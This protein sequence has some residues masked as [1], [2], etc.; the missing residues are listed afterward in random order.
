MCI[1][2]GA[3]QPQSAKKQ[4]VCCGSRKPFPPDCL[5]VTACGPSLLLRSLPDPSLQC[6][7]SLATPASPTSRGARLE[8]S[9]RPPPHR[10]YRHRPLPFSDTIP[11]TLQPGQESLAWPEQR[12]LPPIFVLNSCQG[13]V[14]L[15]AKGSGALRAH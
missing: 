5:R 10:N 7:P 11:L 3:Q 1:E 9:L 15:D 13:F 4:T 14:I 2:K 8:Q 6:D 12:A